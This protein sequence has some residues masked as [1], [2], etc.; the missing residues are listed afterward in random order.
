MQQFEVITFHTDFRVE[1]YY[2]A[3]R[4]DEGNVD[5]W[6]KDINEHD[7]SWILKHFR[8]LLA[9]CSLKYL[10]NIFRPFYTFS[11]LLIYFSFT[12]LL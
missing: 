5:D 10:C 4:G 1:E 3:K 8:M 11:Y 12:L 9:L 7:V 6:E 2:G